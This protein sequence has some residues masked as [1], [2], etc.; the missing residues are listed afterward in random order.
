V[1]LTCTQNKSLEPS[2]LLKTTALMT[3]L[4]LLLLLLPLLVVVA[5]PLLMTEA[6]LPLPLAGAADGDSSALRASGAA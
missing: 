2:S 3:L 4:L 1:L 6:M 5:V